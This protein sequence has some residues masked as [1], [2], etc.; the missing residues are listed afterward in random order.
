MLRISAWTAVTLVLLRLAIGCH[1]FF[2]G[3]HKKHTLDVGETVTSK[4]F[5][6]ENYFRGTHGPLSAAVRSAVGDPDDELL[7]RLTPPA[8]GGVPE[9][10]A[11][12]WDG[13][14]DRF[15]AHYGLSEKQRELARTKF[16]D[17]KKRTAEWLSATEDKGGKLSKDVTRSYPHVT[18]FDVK[19]LASECVAK[20]RQAV[21]DVRDVYAKKL[22]TMGRDVE[23]KRLENDEA[24]V[25]TQRAALQGDLDEQTAAMKKDLESV[26]EP[27][28]KEKPALPEPSKQS[29]AQRY[30]DLATVYGLTVIGAC[31][32]AGLLTR[33]NCLLAAGFLL[34]TYLADPA[35][36]WLPVS[37]KAEGNYFFVNKN[38]VEMFALLA[39]ATTASG[40]WL[41]LDGLLYALFARRPT[42]PRG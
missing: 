10:L 18:T 8:G 28:Q 14:F 3:L 21:A 20:Y 13:Y 6:S 9:A 34:M 7:A 38:L 40:R 24:E 41:G 5:T 17:A 30:L 31:L 1:F 22:P 23:K 26:L 16:E 39:L 11:R 19:T 4:P 37:P 15:A 42:A 32:L 36:P 33:L 2:E 25:R 12:D 29:D 35:F 27:A